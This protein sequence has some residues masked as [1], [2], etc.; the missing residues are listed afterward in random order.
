M[1][2]D[3]TGGEGTE[4]SIAIASAVQVSNSLNAK[5]D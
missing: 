4:L 2:K 5:P 1:L 3:Q